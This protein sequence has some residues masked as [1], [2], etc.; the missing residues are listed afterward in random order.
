MV[1]HTECESKADFK[2]FNSVP[3]KLNAKNP[4]LFRSSDYSCMVDDIG[5]E[6]LPIFL[7]TVKVY[8]L[9]IFSSNPISFI[10]KI[11]YCFYCLHF[12]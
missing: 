12:P 10:H 5:L 7:L 9:V 2:K 6:L 3:E 1:R 4:N 8:S 11:F